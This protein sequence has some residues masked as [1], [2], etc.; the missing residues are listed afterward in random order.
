MINGAHAVLIKD[1][2]LMSEQNKSHVI[3]AVFWHYLPPLGSGGR[4]GDS[5]T[6]RLQL[7]RASK[8]IN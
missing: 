2:L 1:M 4:E 8:H 5:V 3:D 6:F 7:L